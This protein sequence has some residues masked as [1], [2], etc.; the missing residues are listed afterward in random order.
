MVHAPFACTS[1][2]HDREVMNRARR[3]KR[4]TKRGRVKGTEGPRPTHSC[5]SAARR[6]SAQGLLNAG[7]AARP[8]L[9]LAQRLG[10]PGSPLLSLGTTS[11][12]T[13]GHDIPGL[14]LMDGLEKPHIRD[15]G[16]RPD[17]VQCR[18]TGT[19]P[20]HL[21]RILAGRSLTIPGRVVG[22]G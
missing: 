18:L 19:G 5:G 1:K 12:G 20:Q 8:G 17:E 6:A 4:K 2:V 10:Q 7:H 13:L 14:A 11:I 15:A 21:Q 16:L 9:L 3:A 22:L